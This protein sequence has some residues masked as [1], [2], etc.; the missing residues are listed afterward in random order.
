MGEADAPTRAGVL[1][2]R[3]F[4][5]GEADRPA[6]DDDDGQVV[7]AALEDWL[8]RAPHGPL[9][10]G[11]RKATEAGMALIDGWTSGLVDALAR[12]ALGPDELRGV[13][14]SL[15]LGSLRRQL[16][17]MERS[18]LIEVIRCDDGERRYAVTEWLREAVA[19]LI[20]AAH[21]ERHR[22]LD[23][24][25]PPT[26]VD[27]AAAFMLVLPLLE[28]PPEPEGSCRLGVVMRDTTP[29]RAEGVTAQVE[30]GHV[31]LV[32]PRLDDEADAWAAGSATA[33]LD[34][35]IE[36]DAKGVK[37]GGDRYLARV[38]LDGLHERLFGAGARRG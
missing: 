30:G 22:Q 25:A 1:G 33:W 14:P 36:P 17:A 7:H 31:V 6:E 11:E 5:P 28:L 24:S 38:L 21:L 37:T 16:E 35:V 12:G 20:A 3:S 34:T 27:A 4:V 15:R 29:P 2:L 19:P 9:R 32:S 23:D 18:G 10:P 8:A 26:A 13:L